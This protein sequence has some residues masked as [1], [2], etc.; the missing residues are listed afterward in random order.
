MQTDRRRKRGE[1]RAE[2]GG[3]KDRIH[4]QGN[5]VR[6]ETDNS[7]ASGDR[8]LPSNSSSGKYPHLF[9]ARL[10]TSALGVERQNIEKTEQERRKK[11]QTREG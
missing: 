4:H 6:I 8:P 11:E 10:D 2:S 3:W 1:K 7:L 9:F 5:E